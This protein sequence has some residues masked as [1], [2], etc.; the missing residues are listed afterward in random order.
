LNHSITVVFP[1]AL[2]P[3]NPTNIKDTEYA[4]VQSNNGNSQD[5]S[6]AQNLLVLA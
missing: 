5:L 4:P 3:V 6:Q 2:R 1:D